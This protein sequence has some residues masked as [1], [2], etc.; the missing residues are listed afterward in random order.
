MNAQAQKVSGKEKISYLLANIGNIPLMTLLTAFFMIF[1]TDVIGLNPAAL[2]TLYLISKIVDAV[3]DPI[4]G[5]FLDK[6]PVTKMGKF[7]PMLIFGSIICSINYALLWFG[8][9][10]FPQIKYVVVYVTYLLLG[11]TFDVMDISLNSLLPVMTAEPKERNTLSFIKAMGYAFGG[12][13]IAVGGPM[14]VASGTLESYYVLI[15]GSLAIVLVC[16]IV[17]ALGVK[18]RV[19]FEG[20]EEENYSIREMLKFLAC[21]PVAVTFISSLIGAIGS[22][23]ASG[24]NTYFYTYLIGDL[25][26]MSAITLISLIGLVPGMIASPILANKLGKKKVYVIGSTI[27]LIGTTVRLLAPTS[28]PLL[29]ATSIFGSIGAGLVGTLG[30]GIQADNT[31]YVQYQTGRRAEG[32]IASL[33]SLISK[34]GQGIGGAIPGYI[35][36]L[37]GYVKGAEVQAQSAQTGII[38]CVIIIPAVLSLISLVIFAKGYTLDKQQI[39]DI[40][41]AIS[42]GRHLS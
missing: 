4:M 41:S 31:M 12:L 18:E 29:Y 17:G 3:S 36:A 27:A 26:V 25:K 35:L 8:P 38:L 21:A 40:S 14:I 13:I 34:M 24:A 16:S 42:V 5:F 30:Y 11:W 1:Y 19:S 9:V 23:M 7:R 32:A 2:A 22:Q 10:W 6:F 39:E 37:T 20:S 28:L 33:S 15:F